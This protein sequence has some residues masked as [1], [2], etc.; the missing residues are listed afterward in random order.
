MTGSKS[1]ANTCRDKKQSQRRSSETKLWARHAVT[2][3]L[4]YLVAL[5]ITSHAAHRL[6]ERV[7]GV[8]H[9]GLDALVQGPVVGGELVPQSGVDGRS[10]SRGH[11]V[12]VFPQVG[13]VRADGEKEVERFFK[14]LGGDSR[15]GWS[16]RNR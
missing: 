15:G 11:A 2:F 7:P 5:L 13:E 8:V 6:D 3:D 16:W 9:S 10:Q 14:T 12:V 1:S 4:S